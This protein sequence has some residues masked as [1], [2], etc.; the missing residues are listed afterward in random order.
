MH[1]LHDVPVQTPGRTRCS[2][3]SRRSGIWQLGCL[4][5]DGSLRQPGRPR[6]PLVPGVDGPSC[7]RQRR[8]SP[9]LST[10]RPRLTRRVG[11]SPGW[12]LRRVGRADS[13]HVVVSR[14]SSTC[15]T[16][17]P[18]ATTGLTALQGLDAARA[19]AGHTVLIFGAV[20]VLSA[21][22]RC[23]SRATRGARHR[24]RIRLRGRTFRSNAWRSA[25]DRCPPTGSIDQ[26][27]GLPRADL[28][29]CSRSPGR[30]P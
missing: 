1:T 6:F 8:A 14:R 20:P 25:R 27:R 13:A 10:R 11:Q 15:A 17:E 22:W 5:R 2:S 30:W 28:I 4:D 23:S 9:P 12:L 16:P 18:V 7:R 19:S 24:D 29:V 21:A 3:R 26:L